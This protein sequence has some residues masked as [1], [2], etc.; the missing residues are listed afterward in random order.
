MANAIQSIALEELIAHPDNPNRMSKANFAKLLRNI[1]R[2]GRY[3]PLIVRPHPKESD[4]FEII[5]GHHRCDALAQLG[6]KKA[7]CI[8]WDV[9]DEQTDILLAT[10]N[11]LGGSDELGKKLL[12]LK[13]LNKRIEST[14]LGRVLPQSAKQI[15]QLC[16][17]KLPDELAKAKT[18]LFAQP[19]VFFLAENDRQIVENAL[20][21][22]ERDCNEKTKAA[23]NAA[24]LVRIARHFLKN[25]TNRETNKETTAPP[26]PLPAGGQAPAALTQ[27]KEQ[28]LAD[29]EMFEKR[30]GRGRKPANSFNS[31]AGRCAAPCWQAQMKTQFKQLKSRRKK[32]Y[33]MLVRVSRIEVQNND[34]RRDDDTTLSKRHNFA[35]RKAEH[36]Q[37]PNRPAQKQI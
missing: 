4:R 28:T 25:D 8:V 26:A 35:E 11:R 27:R 22:A 19:M 29:I 31:A 6:C 10:L 37:K 23:K 15:E 32:L 12:L 13:R 16:S 36:R 9:D 7:D 33:S 17:L 14:E 21:L 24:A 3:E 30:F 20:S 18:Q 34:C 5:N 2:T 1:E